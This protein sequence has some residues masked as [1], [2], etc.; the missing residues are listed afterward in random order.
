MVLFQ[1]SLTRILSVYVAQGIILLLFIYLPIKILKENKKRIHVIFSFFYFCVTLGIICNFIY[2]PLTDVNIV[3]FLNF[4][5]NYLITLSAIF[6]VVFLILFYKGEEEF[7][8][9]KQLM[10]I[11]TYAVILFL[12]YFIP[13][14]VQI[15]PE[16]DWAPVWSITY[17]LYI[18]IVLTVMGAIPS[19]YYSYK[20]YEKID[21]DLVR[22]KWKV[23]IFGEIEMFFLLYGT[24]LSN[25]INDPTINLYWGIAML[26]LTLTAAYMIYYGVAKRF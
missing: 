4:M 1:L 24:Y 22:K 10:V 19:L 13:D 18:T 2:A 14:G 20:L 15:G 25:V 9:S 6:I 3:K 7:N 16:T 23:F 11:I 21:D 17:F 8:T 5:T 12:V 26:F